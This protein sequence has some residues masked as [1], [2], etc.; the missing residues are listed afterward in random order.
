MLPGSWEKRFTQTML[1]L[2]DQDP[3]QVLSPSQKWALDNLVYRYRRQLAA[4]EIEIPKRLPVEAD[5]LAA[6]EHRRRPVRQA[7]LF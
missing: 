2:V 4:S 5:Y 1:Y 7:K 3:K 6:A